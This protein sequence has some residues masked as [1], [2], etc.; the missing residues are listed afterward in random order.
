MIAST[1]GWSVVAPLTTGSLGFTL[2]RYDSSG[3]QDPDNG[4][5]RID[6]I[7]AE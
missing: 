2:R 4:D 6:V 7:E 1:G 5:W 3:A